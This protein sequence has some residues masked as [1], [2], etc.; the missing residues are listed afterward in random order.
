MAASTDGV[1]VSEGL[2]G[3]AAP[4]RLRDMPAEERPRERLA[5]H[6]AAALSNRELLK[7]VAVD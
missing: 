5:R 3:V 1:G 2:A 7:K 4:S 6:G